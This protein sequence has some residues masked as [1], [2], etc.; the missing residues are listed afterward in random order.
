MPSPAG[1]GGRG[2]AR[3]RMRGE[4]AAIT[5]SR[6][7]LASSALISPLTRTA[8][9]SA[10]RAASGGC[11]STRACGRSPEGEALET[12]KR[13]RFRALFRLSKKVCSPLGPLCEGAPP[14]GGGGRELY[15]CPKYFGLWQGSLPPL[16]RGTAP[17]L[18]QAPPPPYRGSLSRRGRFFD[19]LRGRF[20]ALFFIY[21]YPY[22]FLPLTTNPPVHTSAMASAATTAS[23]MPSTPMM[24]GRVR[25]DTT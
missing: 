1:E 24:S 12:Q 17:P 21:R 15:G 20:R 14:A 6:D 5:H 2:P 23:Q 25:M 10:L 4:C 11:A 16:L 22:L 8:S 19:T 18:A 9:V 7:A 3:G 13:G